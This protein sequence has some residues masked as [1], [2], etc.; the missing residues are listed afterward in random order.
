MSM[1]DYTR[2][3]LGGQ[4]PQRQGG[5]RPGQRLQEAGEQAR[6]RLEEA[7]QRMGEAVRQAGQQTR[8]TRGGL[9]RGIAR[10]RILAAEGLARAAANLR[11]SSTG[12]DTTARRFADNLDRG[13]TYLRQT[14]LSGMQRDA[15]ELVRQYPLQALG[16]AFVVGLAIGQRLSRD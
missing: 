1:S 12:T 7:G 5:E 11:G 9:M 8:R 3:S 14:D 4:A 6:E 13:A 10:A 16:A 2:R 15:I